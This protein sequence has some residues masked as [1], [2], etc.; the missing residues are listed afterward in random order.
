MPTGIGRTRGSCALRSRYGRPCRSGSGRLGTPLDPPRAGS[1]PRT[2]TA[3]PRI[4]GNQH[5]RTSEWFRG[6]DVVSGDQPGMHVS[7]DRRSPARR[8]RRDRAVLDGVTEQLMVRLGPLEVQMCVVFPGE[9]DSAV[10]LDVV[11]CDL[12]IRLR[13]ERLSS[14]D[15]YHALMV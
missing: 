6:L 15:G 5:C 11:A 3:R 13:C 1:A 7:A 12:E 14:R 8:W 4:R 2:Y 9:P 10:N